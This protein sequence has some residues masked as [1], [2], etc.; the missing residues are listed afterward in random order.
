ML[1]ER[2]HVKYFGIQYLIILILLS[3]EIKKYR[4]ASILI[5]SKVI[6]AISLN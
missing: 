6:N 2:V 3:S 1:F 5:R 4:N